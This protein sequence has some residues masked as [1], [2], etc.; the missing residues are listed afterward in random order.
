[1][2]MWGP[3]SSADLRS[4]SSGC[5]AFHQPVPVVNDLLT[6]QTHSVRVAFMMPDD[7]VYSWTRRKRDIP[8][9]WTDA[10]LVPSNT[11]YAKSK[12]C[13]CQPSTYVES[14]SKRFLQV[15]VVLNGVDEVRDAKNSV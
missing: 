6:S 13:S 15:E 14:G 12:V 2:V 8:P 7:G 4:T 11:V 10:E 5:L 1:M 3:L 9:L